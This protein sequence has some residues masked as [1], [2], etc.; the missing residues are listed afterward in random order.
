MYNLTY[1]YGAQQGIPLINSS[2][3]I[4]S[5]N[6]QLIYY[7]PTD[8]LIHQNIVQVQI[9]NNDTNLQIKF[10]GNGA[11]TATGGVLLSQVQF[12]L[13]SSYQASINITNNVTNTTTNTANTTNTNTTNNANVAEQKNRILSIFEFLMNVTLDSYPL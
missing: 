7:T 6:S 3:S 1:T 13:V 10:C 8:Y 9:L 2:F 5:N 12:L 11:P 4:Y